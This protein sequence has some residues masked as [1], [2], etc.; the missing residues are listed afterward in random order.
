MTTFTENNSRFSKSFSKVAT[1]LMLGLSA[2]LVLFPTE[3]VVAKPPTM[4]SGSVNLFYSNSYEECK[5]KAI[6]AAT[7]V[8]STVGKPEERDR[9][10]RMFGKTAQ[11]AV[12]IWCIEVPQGSV[13]T[14]TSSAY[15]ETVHGEAKSVVDR[16]VNLIKDGL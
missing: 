1:R 8:L 14:V 12:V 7:A 10:L 3:K 5:S 4:Y 15:F 11:T 2:S 16:L 13:A 6:K 9:Q